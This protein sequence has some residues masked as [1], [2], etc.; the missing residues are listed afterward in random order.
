MH[1]KCIS[2]V[3]IEIVHSEIGK[4]PAYRE[5]GERG[6]ERNRE[7]KLKWQRI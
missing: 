4:L 6:R 2:P 7:D 5:R 3:N 1:S